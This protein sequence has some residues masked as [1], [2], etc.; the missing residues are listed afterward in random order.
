[1][2]GEINVISR[3]QIIY[4][5]PT[6]GSISIINAGPQ[7]P[8]GPAGGVSVEDFEALAARVAAL[9][10]RNPNGTP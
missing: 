3:T 9:E 2:S 7:G 8:A 5:D 6:S 4:V 10:E 1:M